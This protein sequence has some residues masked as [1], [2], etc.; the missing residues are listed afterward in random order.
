MSGIPEEFV[1]WY[2]SDLSRTIARKLHI[3]NWEWRDGSELRAEMQTLNPRIHDE[4]ESFCQTYRNWATATRT[5]GTDPQHMMPLIQ[6]RE[7]A[8]ESLV[9][10]VAAAA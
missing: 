7:S 9:K 10:A 1:Q 3:K 4:F 5:H 8:L 6:K 2:F